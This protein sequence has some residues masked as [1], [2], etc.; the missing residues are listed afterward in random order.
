MATLRPTSSLSVKPS[1]CVSGSLMAM[2][3]PL[4]S[5]S[6]DA[7]AKALTS[8]PLDES[9]THEARKLAIHLRLSLLESACS[10]T[11][12]LLT[13]WI[14]K[15]FERDDAYVPLSTAQCAAHT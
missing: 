2:M 11:A 4:S 6:T 8:M 3:V 1:S 9:L 10:T 15:A 14:A 7:V 13:R 12:F 5:A